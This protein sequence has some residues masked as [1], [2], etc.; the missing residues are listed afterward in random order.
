MSAHDELAAVEPE[1]GEVPVEARLEPG[2]EARGD[3]RRE[4]RGREE[5]VL[6][7]ALADHGLEREPQRR[8]AGA[9]HRGEGP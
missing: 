4:H 6:G 1:V 7:A 2:G 8:R 9:E 5:D 3:V